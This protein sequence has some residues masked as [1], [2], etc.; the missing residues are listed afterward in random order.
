M[1]ADLKHAATELVEVRG[2]T[3]VNVA[4]IACRFAYQH[5]GLQDV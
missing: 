5:S 4:G 1:L 2:C 3:N